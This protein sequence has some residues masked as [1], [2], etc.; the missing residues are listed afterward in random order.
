MK[1]FKNQFR[2][3]KAKNN[4]K[5]ENEMI[6]RIDCFAKHLIFTFAF[7]AILF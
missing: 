5:M 2:Q 3:Q 4:I 7:K 1:N 6:I